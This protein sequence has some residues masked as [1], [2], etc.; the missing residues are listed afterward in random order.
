PMKPLCKENCK[1]LCPVCGANRNNKN[2]GHETNETYSP[3]TYLLK[4]IEKKE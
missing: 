3:F 1:G 4:R 2:C